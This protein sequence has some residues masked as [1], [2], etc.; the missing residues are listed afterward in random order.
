M[1]H[2][3][4]SR[5][6]EYAASLHR[7]QVRKGTLIPY[8]SHL[9]Q[10]AGLVME[11]GGG[12]D[13]VIAALLHDAIEDAPGGRADRV[14]AEIRTLFGDDVLHIVEACSDTDTQPKP[15]WK[16]RKEDYIRHIPDAD[17]SVLLVSAAD[18]LHNARVILADLREHGDELWK[19]FNASKDESL[20]YYRSLVNAFRRADAPRVL[21]D[22]LDR[23]VT[24]IEGAAPSPKEPG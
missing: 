1:D 15:P 2:E 22:E 17:H 18:K 14:R 13:E 20:W 21:T 23:V 5:A 9:M 12:K 8:I 19:R 24:E 7:D 10:V 3:R 6:F 4:L 11:A 16:K